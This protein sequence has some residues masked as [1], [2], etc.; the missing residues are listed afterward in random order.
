MYNP[1]PYLKTVDWKAFARGPVFIV[2]VA[3]GAFFAGRHFAPESVKVVTVDKVVEVHHE[4]TQT[5]QQLDIDALLKKVQDKTRFV[6]RDVVKI[7]TVKP[8]GTR[9]EQETD[10][11]HIDSTQHTTA[12]S[13]TKTSE[14]TDIK[15]ILDDYR[16]ED[17]T[18]VVEKT[19]AP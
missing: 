12:N 2:L 15:K 3:T 11:S 17:H 8:D 5:V 14:L 18:K 13:E 10:R 19:K 16:S 1:I 9:I 4:Q 6:D 7:V